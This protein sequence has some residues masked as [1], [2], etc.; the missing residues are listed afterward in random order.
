MPRHG[1][2]G[3]S[4][5]GRTAAAY[6]PSGGQGGDHA[7]TRCPPISVLCTGSVRRAFAVEAGRPSAGG[8]PGGPLAAWPGVGHAAAPDCMAPGDAMQWDNVTLT[9]P[10]HH[11]LPGITGRGSG[12]DPDG[13]RL[14]LADGFQPRADLAQCGARVGP[15]DAGHD[16]Q[17]PVGRRGRPAGASSAGSARPSATMRRTARTRRSEVQ[18]GAPAAR[19]ALR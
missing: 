9:V 4:G 2:P 1:Q 12:A 19:R 17:Q 7:Q 18:G 11:H 16:G 10:L 5:T 13:P 15:Q 3:P 6:F 14:Q 8:S